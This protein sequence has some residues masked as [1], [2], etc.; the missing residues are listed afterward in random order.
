MSLIKS[1]EQD[2]FLLKRLK[3]KYSLTIVPFYQ[4]IL[5][6]MRLLSTKKLHIY[7]QISI[8]DNNFIQLESM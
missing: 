5:D 8:I 4:W 7:I 3:H 2:F 6:L 1:L